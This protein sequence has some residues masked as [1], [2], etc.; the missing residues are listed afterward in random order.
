MTL[1]TDLNC[2]LGESF[3]SYSLGQDEAI[4]DWVT[5]VNIACG[6][7][8]GDYNV[9]R[10]TVQL[11]KT[12][13][14]AIGAHPGFYDLIGFGRRKIQ[15]NPGEVYNLVLYQIG[16][17]HAFAK[18]EGI[19]LNHVKPHGALY[20]LAAV[21]T[22]TAEAIV[23]AAASFDPALIIYGLAGSELINVGR[24]YGLRVAEEV[25]ADRTYQPDGTLTPR[26]QPGAIISNLAQAVQQVVTMVT[27]GVVVTADGSEVSVQADTICIHGD[28]EWS[29]AFVRKIYSELKI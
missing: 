20:N 8:A 26:H 14:V 16:A 4:L 13:G 29:L 15:V 7:H 3:G 11:A 18:A 2:D 6:F 10:K 24:K 25:F 17:L 22:S 5:S 28:H 21:D 27:K 19:K 9:M 12:K 1:R 23:K